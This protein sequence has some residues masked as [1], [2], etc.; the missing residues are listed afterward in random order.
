MLSWLNIF[1]NRL[2][3]LFGGLLLLIGS[4]LFSYLYYQASD[5]IRQASSDALVSIGRTNANALAATL[6]EREREIILLS[7]RPVF[8][9]QEVNTASIQSIFELLQSSNPHY[10]WIAFVDPDGK[11]L[12]SFNDLLL[13]D[14]VSARP[15]FVQAQ[16]A[17]YLG[18][19]HEAVLLA[20]QLQVKNTDEPL[21]FVDFAAPVF[22]AN[23]KLLGVVAIHADWSWVK[24]VL[25]GSLPH[26]AKE[27]G[28]EVYIANAQQQLLYPYAS[29]S[30]LSLPKALPASGDS[31]V[32]RWPD[33]AEYV[34]SSFDVNVPNS[35]QLAWKIVVRQPVEKALAAALEL[36]T[37]MLWMGSLAVILILSVTYRLASQMSRPIEQLAR[38][39]NLI[40]AGNE[41]AKFD[42]SSNLQ[43]VKSLSAS[44]QGMTS[45]LL[46]RRQALSEINS[47]LEEKVQERTAALEEANLQLQRLSRR[48]GLTGLQNRRAAEEALQ[49]EFLVLKRSG[50]RFSVL[51]LDVDHFKQVNDKFGHLVGDAVLIDIAKLIQSS[52]RQTDLAA[53]FGGEEF[54][55]LL[56]DT[57]ES[58][59]KVAEKIRLSIEAQTFPEVGRVTVSIG[60]SGARRADESQDE[61]VHRAD[62]ALYEAKRAGRNQVS[63]AAGSF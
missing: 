36:R 41:R 24:V 51:I 34:T 52:V 27:Q 29:I 21:R 39:A 28:L 46:S 10:V 25:Q 32:I 5:K 59:I 35:A 45:N 31:D 2:T 38:V 12:V 58:A 62:M 43:E 56:P 63:I 13:G 48:D 16:H 60:V 33:G 37:T 23:H 4:L 26:D 6:K 8:S 9:Q 40:Q 61:V 49:H 57:I 50:T 19:V 3:L 54:L 42:I 22:N 55:V 30:Q 47:K 17:P 20:K 15:W 44:L 7:K 18:D 1:R 11:V 53:R 14:Y